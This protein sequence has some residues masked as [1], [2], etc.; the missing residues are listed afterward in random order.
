MY[1]EPDSTRGTVTTEYRCIDVLDQ[2]LQACLSAINSNRP[3]HHPRVVCTQWRGRLQPIAAQFLAGSNNL[4]EL[5]GRMVSC[6]P[7]GNRRL[8]ATGGSGGLP[9]RRRLPTCPTTSAEFPSVRKLSGAGTH[10]CRVPTPEDALGSTP[11]HSRKKCRDESV[12]TRQ[13]R[14]PNAAYFY[15]RRSSA[16]VV[17]RAI[18]PAAAFQ[19]AFPVRERA[20]VGQRLA[21]S[22]LQPGLAAPQIRRDGLQDQKVCGIG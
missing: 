3:Y 14:V 20:F 19:A 4:H 13:A 9:T 18:L 10:A 2:E 17:G 22:R 16:F 6:A 5:W 11:Y 8:L 21:E 12:S 7:V 15:H 1:G